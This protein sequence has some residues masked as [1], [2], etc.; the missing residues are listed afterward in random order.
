MRTCFSGR[1]CGIQREEPKASPISGEPGEG[2]TEI[3]RLCSC[4]RSQ[5]IRQRLSQPL[6]KEGADAEG[7]RRTGLALVARRPERVLTTGDQSLPVTRERNV[8]RRLVRV[9][10]MGAV[11]PGGKCG[12]GQQTAYAAEAQCQCTTA[13]QGTAGHA[14]S[15]T[16]RKHATAKAGPI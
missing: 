2:R 9:S 11:D 4:W 13:S 6:N 3:L 5:S 8:V 1:R 16:W 12:G 15:Q 14:A 7:V 10:T